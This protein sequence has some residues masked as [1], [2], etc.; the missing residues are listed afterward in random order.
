MSGWQV[1]ASRSP[2]YGSCT[3]MDA[4]LSL[5]SWPLS[6]SV[7]PRPRPSRVLSDKVLVVLAAPYNAEHELSLLSLERRIQQL[8]G[9]QVETSCLISTHIHSAVMSSKQN[10]SLASLSNNMEVLPV[11]SVWKKKKKTSRL[12]LTIISPSQRS[13][14]RYDL[15][16]RLSKREGAVRGPRVLKYLIPLMTAITSKQ[17]GRV[18]RSKAF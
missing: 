16:T 15:F 3:V 4:F 11:V 9:I 5:M 18:R 1:G 17:N 2:C 6:T 14:P 13:G 12:Q 8:F 7:S 10:T